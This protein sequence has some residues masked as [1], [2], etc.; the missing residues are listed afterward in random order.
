[1]KL[2]HHPC[3][4]ESHSKLDLAEQTHRSLCLQPSGGWLSTHLQGLA[5][6]PY[7]IANTAD[8]GG[9]P[10]KSEDF[11]SS[12]SLWSS[13]LIWCFCILNVYFLA[14]S[15]NFEIQDSGPW[16]WGSGYPPPPPG[17]WVGTVSLPLSISVAFTRRWIFMKIKMSKKHWEWCLSHEII[18]SCICLIT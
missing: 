13:F 8:S 17:L 7:G 10:E 5:H 6:V 14:F 1:M 18:C 4:V 12:C 2:L 3:L 11:Y 9:R 15:P 16:A